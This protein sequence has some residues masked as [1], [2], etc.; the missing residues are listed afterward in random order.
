[1][2][3]WRT[4]VTTAI[5]STLIGHAAESNAHHG[6]HAEPLY[7]TSALVEFEGE[8]TEVFWRD[9]HARFRI[10]VTSGPETG[11]IWQIETNPPANLLRNGFAPELMPIGSEV[12]VAGAVSGG[13]PDVKAFERSNSPA[14]IKCSLR[15][16]RAA[17]EFS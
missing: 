7:D 13:L 10:W 12:K 5:S 11:E 8:V 6:P 14:P 1:M 16:A 2:S 3:K 17:S 15:A 9:P 4:A